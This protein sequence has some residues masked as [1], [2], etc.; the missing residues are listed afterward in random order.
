MKTIRKI[1]AVGLAALLIVGGG[2]SAFAQGG[3]GA[4]LNQATNQTNVNT[5]LNRGGSTLAQKVAEL[6]GRTVESVIQERTTTQKTYGTI[7]NE[8]GKLEEFKDVMLAEK[9]A[10]VQELV[11]LGR[12]TQDQANEFLTNLEQNMVNCDGT[13]S[14][15]LG[16]NAGGLGMGQGKVGGQGRGT[17]QGLLGSKFKVFNLGGISQP[18][19]KDFDLINF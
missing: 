8:A 12:M 16:K 10:R 2:V 13:G 5:R 6:T 14:Q 11:N 3:N 19:Y 18:C 17:G 7:A 9:K 15:G 1:V 4:K